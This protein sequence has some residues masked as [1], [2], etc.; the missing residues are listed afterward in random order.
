MHIDLFAMMTNTI[1]ETITT[2]T[3][4]MFYLLFHKSVICIYLVWL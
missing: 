2:R 4:L 1:Q 3:I